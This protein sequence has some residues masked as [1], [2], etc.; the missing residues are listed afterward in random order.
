MDLPI[1]RPVFRC[2]GC[3]LSFCRVVFSI[4]VLS[5]L[6]LYSMSSL[7]KGRSQASGKACVFATLLSSTRLLLAACSLLVVLLEEEKARTRR[8]RRRRRCGVVTLS[9][10]AF[11]SGISGHAF[12][13]SC[14]S[15]PHSQVATSQP[16]GWVGCWPFLHETGGGQNQGRTSSVCAEQFGEETTLPTNRLTERKAPP[17][18]R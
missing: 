6:L 9:A 15:S 11:H 2:L 16:T 4:V 18:L 7:G 3:C 12:V 17:L 8:R 5:C 10:G 14:K 13:K 1:G